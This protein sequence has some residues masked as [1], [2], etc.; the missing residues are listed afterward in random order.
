MCHEA[1]AAFPQLPRFAVQGQVPLCQSFL[2][3]VTPF[4]PKDTSVLWGP[5][6]S[7][8]VVPSVQPAA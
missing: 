8:T 7:H 5:F 3:Q 4:H 1:P 2:P 6:S